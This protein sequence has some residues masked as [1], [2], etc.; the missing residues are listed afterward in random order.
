MNC[1]SNTNNQEIITKRRKRELSVLHGTYLTNLTYIPTKI[2]S[3]NFRAHRSLEVHQILVLKPL[4]GKI[5]RKGKKKKKKFSFL[6]ATSLLDLIHN[7]TKYYQNISK[8]VCIIVCARSTPKDTLWGN[9][10]KRIKATIV[11]LAWDMPTYSGLYSY[12]TLSKNLKRHRSC[13]NIF[14]DRQMDGCQADCYISPKLF[15]CGQ[16]GWGVGGKNALGGQDSI[17]RLQKIKSC[18]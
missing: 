11:I 6:H 1:T 16:W 14:T 13:R 2:L 3:K 7:T 10:Y 5:T 9:N 17:L 8:H 12:K 18:L 4:Q 15:C